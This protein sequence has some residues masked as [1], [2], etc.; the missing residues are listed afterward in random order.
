M[1]VVDLP[2]ARLTLDPNEH[3]PLDI[4]HV[5]ALAEGRVVDD[6]PLDVRRIAGTRFYRITN[7]RHRYFAAVIRGQAR[8]RVR[9]RRGSVAAVRRTWS[10]RYNRRLEARVRGTY[11]VDG[12]PW[13]CTRCRRYTLTRLGLA[14]HILACQ[15]V[16]HD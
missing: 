6:R 13:H 4:T 5:L 3:M 2:L 1:P 7:G 11:L 15:R 8:V 16:V 10:D 12:A 9:I 14:L